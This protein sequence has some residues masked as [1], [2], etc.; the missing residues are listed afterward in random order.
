MN[1]G[2]GIVIVIDDD[3]DVR[4]LLSLIANEKGFEAWQARDCKEGMEQMR[5][6]GDR[7]ALVLLDYFMPGMPPIDC[8][9]AVLQLAGRQVEVVLVTAAVDPAE[10]ARTIGLRH[11]V[12]K[13]FSIDSIDWVWRLAAAR[14]SQPES[15]TT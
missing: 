15:V 13:P 10:R 6:A 5:R 14:T 9:R 11:W 2:A 12:G 4:D 8:C 1:D 7:L 3:Q